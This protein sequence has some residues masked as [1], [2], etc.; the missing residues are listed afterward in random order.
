EF[1]DILRFWFDRG[2]A[3]FRIDVCNIIVK[4]RLLRDNPVATAADSAEAQLFG[5]RAVY[6]M[7]RPEAHGVIRRWRA[8]ADSY[9]PPRVLLGETPVEELEHTARVHCTDAGAHVC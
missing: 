9:D 4:D 3:G 7:N 5:Q 1:D 8:I 2:V 6:N